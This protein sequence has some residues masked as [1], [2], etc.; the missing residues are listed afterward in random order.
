MGCGES[1]QAVAT[2]NTLSKSKSKNL[3][4][5]PPIEKPANDVE[6]KTK[7][8]GE[9]IRDADKK[10]SDGGIENSLISKIKD[11]KETDHGG[12]DAKESGAD[13]N[14]VSGEENIKK[15]DDEKESISFE[16]ILGKSD[17]HSAGAKGDDEKDGGE[18]KLNREKEE[19]LKVNEGKAA[20]ATDETKAS[21]EDNISATANNETA[22]AASTN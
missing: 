15:D 5:N 17:Y 9:K 16:G 8:S 20:A 10:E 3:E 2:E 11:D 12:R 18:A 22:N 14:D 6:T 21:G 19:V 13:E 7:E 1:K 4:N